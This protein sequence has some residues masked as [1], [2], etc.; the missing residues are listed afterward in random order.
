MPLYK[1]TCINPQCQHSEEE[2]LTHHQFEDVKEN[3]LCKICQTKMKLIFQPAALQFKGTGF[4]KTD[5]K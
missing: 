5:Y 1:F 3:K 4:Y 2:L